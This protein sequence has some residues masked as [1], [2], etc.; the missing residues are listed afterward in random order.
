MS[1]SLWPG[2]LQ[3]TRLPYPWPT[4]GGAC[5]NWSPSSYWCHPTISS[6]F[7]PFSCLQSFP[8]LGSFPMSQFFTSGGQSIG[9]SASS[10]V[11]KMNIRDWFSLGLTGWIT[12]KS[13][14]ITRVFS[15]TVVQNHQFFRTQLSL[16]S[17]SHIHTWLLEKP[18]L[19]LGS[20][21]VTNSFMSDSL[22][23]HEPQHIRPPYLSATP[24]VHPNPCPLSLWCHPNISSSVGPFSSCLQS[25]HHQGLFQW[26]SSS[27]QV[28][29]VLE[30]QLQLQSFQWR[31]RTNLL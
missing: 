21:Q 2:G 18:W 17:N 13:K 5:S 3:N 31:P 28:A 6:C 8:D 27:H 1:Y 24:G 9:V 4:P 12:L 29:K 7:S 15:N 16:W 23:P 22:W 19:W 10:S 30:F 14:G 20:L 26:V 25:S 11:L